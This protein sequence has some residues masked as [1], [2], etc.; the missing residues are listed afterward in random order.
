MANELET[1][2][3]QF[4]IEST[5]E[6]GNQSLIEGF[7][8]PE[9][10]TTKEEQITKIDPTEKKKVEK[11]VEKKK[12]EVK[13]K[14]EEEK[15]KEEEKKKTLD[16]DKLVN[17]FLEE[18]EEEEREKPKKKEETKEGEE[19]EGSDNT[20]NTLSKDLLRLG[21]F[22]KEEGEED[23]EINSA[24]EFLERFNFEKKKGAIEVVDNF[25][26]QFGPEWQEAFDAIYVKG[27]HPKEYFG[28]YNVIEDFA[29]LDLTV[30][31]NQEAIVK[32]GFLDMGIPA[33]KIA[34]KL[35]KIKSYGDLEEEAKSFHEI[36]VKKQTAKLD[37]LKKDSETKIQQTAAIKNQYVKNVNTILQDKLKSK[38]FDGIP[39]NPKLAAE[40]QDFL[41][42]DKYKTPSGET[43]T[44]FDK[45]ILELKRPEN[46]EKKVKLALILKTLEKDP[47]LSTIQRAGLTKKS[48]TL[49]SEL[50]KKTSKSKTEK[51][52][53]TKPSTWLL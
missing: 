6:L 32:Q 24:E 34:A 53:Q 13:S 41:I 45:T 16:K 27:V 11:V 23:I 8:S 42:S 10:I 49:F 2:S 35:E 19:E 40:L 46:H 36:L 39:I 37:Q 44:E 43:L 20:F 31:A 1:P 51:E 9:T 38:D 28:T 14:E 26:G 25:I 17:D 4:N 50:V 18:E 47:T 33:D 21:V 5:T 22:S 12:D 29:S 30:E 7:L 52:E 3:F 48:D 15:A